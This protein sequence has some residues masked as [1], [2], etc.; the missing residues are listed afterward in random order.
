MKHTHVIA[1]GK[2][3]GCECAISRKKAKQ[4]GY[5]IV[6]LGDI[7]IELDRSLLNALPK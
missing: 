4:V 5:V 6:D 7:K 1:M 2:Y 3:K